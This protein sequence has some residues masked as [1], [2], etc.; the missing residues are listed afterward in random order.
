MREESTT[1]CRQ[2]EACDSLARWLNDE[3]KKLGAREKEIFRLRP[4][5]EKDALLFD[6]QNEFEEIR[7]ALRDLQER[8]EAAVKEL[9]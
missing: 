1:V 3:L 5:D 7:A 9:L 4:S 2:A 6:V 8:R